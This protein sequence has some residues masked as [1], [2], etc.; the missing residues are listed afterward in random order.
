MTEGIYKTLKSWEEK[1][2]VSAIVIFSDLEKSFCCGGDIKSLIQEK[3]MS[4]LEKFFAKE[5]KM[6]HFLRTMKTPVISWGE[7]YIMGGGMGIFLGGSHP[8]VTEKAIFSMPEISVGFFTDVG[9]TH[10]FNQIGRKG[11]F[12]ALTGARFNGKEA[13]NFS[14]W[15]LWGISSEKKK[16]LFQKLLETSFAKDPEENQK[17]VSK[18]LSSF[19]DLEACKDFPKKMEEAENLV[20]EDSLEACDENLRN[21]KGSSSF[22]KKSIASYLS[23]SPFSAAVIFRQIVEGEGLNLE[24]SFEREWNIALRLFEESDV[25]EGVRA[26]LVDKDKNPKWKYKTA[27]EVSKEDLERVFTPYSSKSLF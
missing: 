7:G 5:Y 27:K 6:D 9:G 10:F 4:Y 8:I 13:L 12:L 3:D 21:Y 26:L 2:E 15:N 1:K 22:I 20:K 11:L 16:D 14:K 17:I 18:V 24:E 19:K 25:Y 23:G